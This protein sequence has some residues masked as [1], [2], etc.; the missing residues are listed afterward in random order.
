M[1]FIDKCYL[2]VKRSFAYE[3]NSLPDYNVKQTRSIED[4]T[5][6]QPVLC[7]NSLNP[8]PLAYRASALPTELLRPDIYRLTLTHLDTR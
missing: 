5:G 6:V 8:G 3:F 4:F 1:L 2:G 7:P